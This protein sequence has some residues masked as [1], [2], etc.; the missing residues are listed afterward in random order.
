[1]HSLKEIVEDWGIQKVVH[2]Y[3]TFWGT[4]SH[5]FWSLLKQNKFFFLEAKQGLMFLVLQ[6][7]VHYASKIL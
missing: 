3:G 5:K 4:R 6:V 7:H 2:G 1:M